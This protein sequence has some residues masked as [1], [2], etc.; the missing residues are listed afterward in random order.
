ME[1]KKTNIYKSKIKTKEEL[2]Q[3][4]SNIR[5]KFPKI[6]IVT[7]NGAFDIIHI[8]HI[9]SLKKA[10]QLGDILIIGLNSDSSIKKYKSKHRPIIP[11]NGRAKMLEALEVVDYIVIFDESDI[12]VP[13]INLIKPN[14]HVKS[15]SGYKGFEEP[16]LNRYGGELHLLEDIKNFENIKTISTSEIIK[17][18]IDIKRQESESL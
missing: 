7:T 1:Y 14:I 10:K 8:G 18:I 17:K 9:A 13:L 4:I 11:Q 6:K 12:S 2:K 3:I 5:N 16:V 15:K